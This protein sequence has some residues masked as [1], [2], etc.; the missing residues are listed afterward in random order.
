MAVALT[1]R[2]LDET[3]DRIYDRMTQTIE[4]EYTSKIIKNL[5]EW[6]Y[7]PNGLN[8]TVHNIDG[9]RMPSYTGHLKLDISSDR[10]HIK[11]GRVTLDTIYSTRVGFCHNVNA[12]SN[13]YPY[14]ADDIHTFIRHL[15]EAL[16]HE[17]PLRNL[18]ATPCQPDATSKCMRV[19]FEVRDRVRE[20]PDTRYDRTFF[21]IL[22]VLK[23]GMPA[24]FDITSP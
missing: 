1:L 20:H 16:A 22:F 7:T 14:W 19:T 8:I 2:D 10:V 24:P 6:W 12:E 13:L 23:P 18:T 21:R 3:L 17:K 11:T 4:S 5:K 9:T 15:Y